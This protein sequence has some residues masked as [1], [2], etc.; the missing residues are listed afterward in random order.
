MSTPS[1]NA[2]TEP[3][4][5]KPA[6]SSGDLAQDPHVLDDK[7]D[8]VQRMF[9]AI[10]PSYD[11]NN[12]IHSFGQDQRWRRKG[13]RLAAP[14]PES[15]VVDVA[16]GT[17][18][19]SEAFHDHGVSQ[20]IGVDFTPEMLD[21][22]RERAGRAG[23]TGLEYRHGDAM[24]LDLPTDSA[25]VLS[26]AFGI[27]NV[28]DPARALAEFR[29]ILRPGG[30]LLI[31]EFSQPSNPMIRLFN[32]LYCRRIMPLTATILSGDRSGAYRY[33]PKS[34]ETFLPRAELEAAIRDAGFDQIR[35]YPMTFGVCVG[36]LAS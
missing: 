1:P 27:R 11:F 2:P 21:V 26:I 18:D 17:G 15:V 31:L 32:N 16:C 4:P 13:V 24:D 29:R 20:V 25:D 3:T 28:S 9:G 14:G 36:Y 8:R 5:A 19:L 12:R 6:W 34:I 22:A 35:Q 10:A 30:R 23:R 33:L 7:A